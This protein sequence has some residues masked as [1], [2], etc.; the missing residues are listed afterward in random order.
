MNLSTTRVP[1]LAQSI[2]A[3]NDIP[4]NKKRVPPIGVINQADFCLFTP[5]ITF[6]DINKLNK[7]LICHV[8]S[9]RNEIIA[10]LDAIV[11]NT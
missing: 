3:Q 4:L 9:S 10:A 2:E 11:T 5:T 8:A 1:L 6:L 7:N